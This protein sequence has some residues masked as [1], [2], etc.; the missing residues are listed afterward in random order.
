MFGSLYN[1]ASMGRFFMRGFLGFL[2]LTGGLLG[3]AAP[4]FAK[5]FSPLQNE[6]NFAGLAFSAPDQGPHKDH[7]PKHG[8]TFFM[9]LDNKH[10]LEGTFVAPGIFRIYLYDDHTKPLNAE[11]MKQVRGTI[12]VGESDT[13]PK[14]PL[15]PGSRKETLEAN[16]GDRV[17]F[18]VTIS[19]QLHLPGMESSAKPEWF[20][21][22]FTK[23]TD[24]RGSGNCSPMAN[25]PNMGC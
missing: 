9:S 4:P 21:F 11:E 17:R 8:G 1:S 20:N 16:L 24:E 23:F 5:T 19:L 10:H 2:V 3:I 22:K 18:P 25:M 6:S 12:Q 15:I 7:N 14:I 13:A